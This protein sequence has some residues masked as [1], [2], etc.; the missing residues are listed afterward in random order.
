MK[1]INKIPAVLILEDGKVF[2]GKAAGKIG[3]STGEICFNTGMT[4]YQEIFT[5]PSYLGQLVVATNVHIGNYGIKHSEVESGSIKIAG[6][7]CKNFNNGYSRVG[8]DGDLNEYF[9]NSNIVGICDIDTRALV[10]YIRNK[11]AMN[12]IISSEEVDQKILIDRLTSVPSMEG[13]ELSS[14]VSTP[15]VYE[16]GASDSKF[17]VAVIDLGAKLNIIRCLTERDCFVRVFPLQSS[18]EEILSWS[19]DGIMLTN[20]PGDPSV[21]TGIVTTVSK[22]IELNIPMFGICLGHQIIATAMGLKTYKMHNGHR[23]IN[24]PIKNLISGRCEVTSQN[25]GFVVDMEAAKAN[26][27]IRITHIHLNDNT[28]AGIELVD[29]KVFSVQYHPEAAPG[30]HDSRYLFDQFITYLE[31][32]QQTLASQALKQETKTN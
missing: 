2:Y 18:V 16:L 17:K 28:L 30:P 6:L 12:A 7:I 24:H 3:T 21:M 10:R 32:F 5:D 13:L 27:N 22:L 9:V 23:G 26:S 15:D 1:F 8:G 19:P 20:G 14:K 4:G 31:E 11:G 29:K 25:H